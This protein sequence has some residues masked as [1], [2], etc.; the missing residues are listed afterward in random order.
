MSKR[1]KP[2]A[3]VVQFKKPAGINDLVAELKKTHGEG[4]DL[5]EV[6][7]RLLALDDAEREAQAEQDTLNRL[8]K[9][10]MLIIEHMQKAG[11]FPDDNQGKKPKP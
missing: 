10:A 7:E 6:A 5:E 11:V 4:V 8:S 2:L 9:K 1:K 3:K